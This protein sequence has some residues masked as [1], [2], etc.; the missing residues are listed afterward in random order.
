MLSLILL[1]G[2]GSEPGLHSASA[3]VSAPGA[4]ATQVSPHADRYGLVLGQ[5]THEDVQAWLGAHNLTCQQFPA[6]TLNSFYYRCDGDLP[7]TLLPDRT[8]HGRLAQIMIS[9]PENAPIH[10]LSTLRKYS[11]AEDAIA[12]F[13][14]SAAAIEA[15]LG[16][17]ALRQQVDDPS[18]LSR[19]LA[20][21]AA[22][23]KG[24][25]LEASVVLLKATGGF[26][27]VTETWTAPAL[28]ARV[29]QRP[30][31]GSVQG[32]EGKRPPGWNP[33]VTETPT[34]NPR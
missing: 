23:W 2:C 33:H 4:P 15:E 5:S 9:R 31:D 11:L 7:L 12:D 21:Y 26:I 27:S 16:A 28:K 3:A 22:D 18:A 8:I 10:H 25:D 13:E 20:R 1:I 24:E 17:P 19:P 30:R 14:S 6:P 29:S 32:G 34:I